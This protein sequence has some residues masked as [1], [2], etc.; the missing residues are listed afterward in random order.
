MSKTPRRNIPF[1][2]DNDAYS[3]FTTGKP[4]DYQAWWNL[5]AKVKASRMTPLW[6]IIPDVV[7]DR[8]ATLEQWDM[9]NREVAVSY[10]WK[11]ALAVQDGMTRDDVLGLRFQPDVIFVGGTTEWK[12]KTAHV[13]CRDFPRV[14]IGRVR[15]RRLRYCQQIG[16]ESCDGTGWMRESTNGRPARQLEAWLEDQEPHPELDLGFCLGR[17]RRA[18]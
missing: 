16:A 3:C 5:M 8:S 13:W 14:H 11:T 2:L 15:T 4:Y 7:G 12:W 18:E 17:P 6:S 10:G 1:A 9:F